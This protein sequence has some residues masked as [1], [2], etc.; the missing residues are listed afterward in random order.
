M[1]KHHEEAVEELIKYFSNR[2]EV[3][4][5]VFDGSV[6]RGDERPDSDI[7]AMIIV[8]P[9]HYKKLEEMNCTSECITGYCNY[10]GG[11]FDVKY[12][13]KDYI[14]LAADKASEPTRHSFIGARVLFTKDEEITDIVSRIPVFQKDEKLDKQLSFYANLMLN[15][16]YFWK[17]C[18]PSGY[19]KSRVASEIVYSIYRMILQENEI[20]FPCNRRLE[21]KVIKA[22]HKPQGI[23]EKC[24]EFLE[25]LNSQLLDEIVKEFLDWT[26]Y[27]PPEGAAVGSRYVLDFE[28]W[29]I[30]P[31]PN[32]NEW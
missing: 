20:L 32:I 10:E 13:T 29:W 8:T 24:D 11:Y 28:Q 4:A 15:Y 5:L 26:S 19:M 22:E 7:D 6:A 3:I 25:N 23:V 18:K 1:Y 21:E 31:R 17:D 14:K 27:Q 9:E 16:N 2:D 12:M 30:Y